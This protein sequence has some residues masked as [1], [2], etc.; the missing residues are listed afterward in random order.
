MRYW[1]L[2]YSYTVFLP[3]CWWIHIHF[4]NIWGWPL[5]RYHGNFLHKSI[6][7]SHHFDFWVVYHNIYLKTTTLSN[8]AT[9]Q[10]WCKVF[11]IWHRYCSCYGKGVDE[12]DFSTV[13]KCVLVSWK[14][15][16]NAAYQCMC[17][18]MPTAMRVS[19]NCEGT[20]MPIGTT[21]ANTTAKALSAVQILEWSP[22]ADFN[23]VLVEICLTKASWNKVRLG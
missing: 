3:I 22:C 15:V 23:T 20:I 16:I 18:T 10:H 2:V 17:I 19:K 9:V 13:R 12:Y 1:D 11:K 21:P 7:V 5:E 8:I 14:H 6:W 4:V